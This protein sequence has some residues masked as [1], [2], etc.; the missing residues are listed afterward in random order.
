MSSEETAA[1]SPSNKPPTTRGAKSDALV[2]DLPPGE[3]PT[4]PVVPILII[5]LPLV[6][7]I[8]YAIVSG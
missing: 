1:T 7:L 8:I 2:H 3:K 4:S 5:S 6:A